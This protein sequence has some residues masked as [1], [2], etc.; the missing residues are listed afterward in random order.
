MEI[1]GLWNVVDGV[2]VPVVITGHKKVYGAERVEIIGRN[3]AS[4]TRRWVSADK[5]K[6]DNNVR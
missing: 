2:W 1:T 3:E 6:E 4:V 5:V